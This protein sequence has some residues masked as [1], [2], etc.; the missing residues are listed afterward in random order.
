MTW[1]TT[2]SLVN[3]HVKSLI[4]YDI[5]AFI[6]ARGDL[7]VQTNLATLQFLS[8]VTGSVSRPIKC[9]I[10]FLLEKKD[11]CIHSILAE[12]SGRNVRSQAENYL[13]LS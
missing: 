12:H 6:S 1:V 3:L 2:P 13:L 8:Q 4:I 5:T 7:F 11:R 10:Y 9:V